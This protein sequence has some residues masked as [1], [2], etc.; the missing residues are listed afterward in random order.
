MNEP[1]R[2]TAIVCGIVI[3]SLPGSARR[4]NAPTI[5]PCSARMRMKTMR[6]TA[7]SLPARHTDTRGAGAVALAGG[8]HAVAA[9]AL[10]A[11]ALAQHG[12]PAASGAGGH[13]GH[14]DTGAAHR[15]AAAT[16]SRTS[17]ASSV[18]IMW[19]CRPR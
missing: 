11:P 14:A 1:A 16:A 4:A 10:E 2:P 6:L 19:A 8:A 15:D 12:A 9:H 3:G 18:L 7:A 13:A 5:R 17:A